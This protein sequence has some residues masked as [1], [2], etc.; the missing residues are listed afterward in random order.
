MPHHG[1]EPQIARDII[2]LHHELRFRRSSAHRVEARDHHRVSFA[3]YHACI[4]RRSH[5]LHYRV[6]IASAAFLPF[7]HF[8]A[9]VPGQLDRHGETMIDLARKYRLILTDFHASQS[10]P[11]DVHHGKR[12]CR[13]CLYCAFLTLSSLVFSFDSMSS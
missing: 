7:T 11:G 13:D 4:R 1:H 9:Q 8:I 5:L 6:C 10:E 3:P 12:A 2:H